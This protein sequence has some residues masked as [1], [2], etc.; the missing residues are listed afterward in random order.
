MTALDQAFAKAYMQHLPAAIQA[1]RSTKP[2]ATPEPPQPAGR[3]TPKT[4]KTR[5]PTGRAA[6]VAD[7]GP[8]P[9]KRAPGLG[10]RRPADRSQK[11]GGGRRKPT[12]AARPPAAGQAA[13][14]RQRPGAAVPDLTIDAISFQLRPRPELPPLTDFQPAEVRSTGTS[15]T[16]TERP[17]ENEAPSGATATTGGMG[18][19]VP[20][21]AGLTGLT[22][23]AAIDTAFLAPIVSPPSPVPNTV[24][25]AP[26]LP[27]PAP[28]SLSLSPFRP[29]LEVEGFQWPDDCD[30]FFRA[31][32]EPLA[33]LARSVAD[34][35][36]AGAKIVAVSSCRRGSGSTTLVLSLA[37]RLAADGHRLLLVDGD[38][39]NP[40]LARR[41]GLVPE[42]GWEEVLAGRMQAE[43]VVIESLADRLALL[44][45][46]EPAPGHAYRWDNR[47]DP[48]T[49]LRMLQA[50]YD[51]VLVD[52][53]RF[54]RQEIDQLA[55]APPPDGS[56]IDRL[57]LVY[58][59]RPA[60]QPEL[61]QTRQAVRAAG[62]TE[63]GVVE[64]FA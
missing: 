52:L 55:A 32:A 18:E 16:S 35:A 39:Y 20:E 46:R 4:A 1:G 42:R 7:A 12:S 26:S 36:A 54:D 38:F 47:A 56:W 58:D 10:R 30:R 40:L 49:S 8:T 60:A 17:P 33:D 24:S 37:R 63:L 41:L 34:E 3:P 44:P 15:R 13:A 29:L 57:L 9:A 45:L 31:L 21:I 59:V 2:M 6:P 64:N 14:P 53:G 27:A 19:N 43:E 28:Y 48:A 5:K 62:I 23:E 50:H 11:R 25:L 51:V 61:A 22:G